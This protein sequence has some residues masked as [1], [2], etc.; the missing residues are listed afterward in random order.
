MASARGSISD[1]TDTPRTKVPS[2]G[3]ISIS[4]RL[5]SARSASRTEVRLTTNFWAR[6]RSGGS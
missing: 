1:S 2:P 6:S 5:S 3:R 4:P